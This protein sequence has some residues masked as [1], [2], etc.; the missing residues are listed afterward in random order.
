MIDEI[1]KNLNGHILTIEDPIEFVHT[2]HKC[3]ISQREIGLHTPGASPKPCTPGCVR[4][5]T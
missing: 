3:L 4:T 1:N 5:R 2:R